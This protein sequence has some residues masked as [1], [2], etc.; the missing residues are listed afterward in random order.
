MPGV[1][2]EC[3]S[4]KSDGVKFPA[5]VETACEKCWEPYPAGFSHHGPW[6]VFVQKKQKG[7]VLDAKY[8]QAK[9]LKMGAERAAWRGDDVK[10]R[11]EVAIRVTE[12]MVG[13]SR[14]DLTAL[15]EGTTP[16][17]L[18]MQLQLLQKPGG[19]KYK[20]ALLPGP[21]SPW[22]KFEFTRT[23]VIEQTATVLT[24]LDQM[25]AQQPEDIFEFLR[26]KTWRST[27]FEEL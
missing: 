17:E 16:E 2:L 7:H 14:S 13:P 5:N 23:K 18:G 3:G 4:K 12:C 10:D 27:K 24:G 15:L 20:G 21:M 1:C 26:K 11:D 8:Q 19:E 22:P 9:R 6:P 25:Y